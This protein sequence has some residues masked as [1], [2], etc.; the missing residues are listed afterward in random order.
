MD[1]TQQRLVKVVPY[2]SQWALEFAREAENICKALGSNC[3]DIHH[4]GSTSVSGLAAKPI[5][6]MLP[7]VK[8]IQLSI[9][10]IQE[11][12][13]LGYEYKGEFGILFRRYF[14]KGSQI[15]THNVHIFE[16]GNTEI[17]RH[18][19]F[20]D[21]MRTHIDDREA[22]AKLKQM[23][24]QKYLHDIFSYC[25]GK[26]KFV[27]SI[28][29]KAGFQGYR[30]VQVA[31]NGERLFYG[32]LHQKCPCSQNDASGVFINNEQYHLVFFK[33]PELVGGAHIDMSGPADGVIW[34]FVVDV[35]YQ[36]KGYG[37]YILLQLE[38][39]LH[40][41][42]IKTLKCFVPQEQLQ[43]FLKKGYTVQEHVQHQ[44]FKKYVWI[45][46]DITHVFAR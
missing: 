41:H 1:I 26:D 25:C 28:D 37:T 19:K 32:K 34:F 42:Q 11:M 45:G 20:R 12:E 13:Q 24:A 33:G 4:I 22:Y 27:A 39:W 6:D 43:F 8:D 40:Q 36:R 35:S 21:W 7:V 15:R 14:Q 5:I 29:E 23:L 44:N 3:I 30:L 31:S 9:D 46:K 10:S 18:L 17:D 16:K 2:D 38:K